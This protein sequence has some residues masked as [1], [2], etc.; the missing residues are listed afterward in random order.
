MLR[1]ALVILSGNAA[2]S[3]LLLARN[4]IVA[5]LIPVEDFGVAAT[6]AL[7]MALVEM[8]STF[9]LQQQIVQSKDGDDPRFQAALQGFQ[10]LRGVLSGLALF[11][12]AGP[13]ARFLEIPQVIWAYQLLALVPVLSAAQH[14][15]IHR[16]TRQMRFGPMI[17]TGA[18]PALAAVLV[19]WPLSLWFGDWQIML[20]SILVQAAL[21]TAVSHLLAE[22]PWRLVLD[23][24]VIAGS[25]RFG[26]PL[27][28]NA[29]LMFLIFQGD[30]LIVGR[31]LGM[32]ALA[33][34]SMGVTLTL[35]P[36]L[37]L[38]KSVQNL[39]LPKLS[40]AKAD[41]ARF[42]R[43]AAAAFQIHLIFGSALVFGAALF[44]PPILHLLLGPKYA[45]L[46][47]LLIWMAV[48]QALRLCKGGPSAVA[49]ARGQTE[50][51]LVA[52]L[53]RVAL[54]PLAWWVVVQGGDVLIVVQLG[55]LGEGVGLIVALV[56]QRVRQGV[57]LRPLLAPLACGV[58][59]G[60][61]A[62]LWA[63]A[64]PQALIW[65]SGAGLGL[66]LALSRDLR[67][68]RRR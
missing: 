9:G 54:L 21:G 34:F 48:Q 32:A 38:A 63:N 30:R 36:T 22:R 29:A 23:R 52:N 61:S 59:S 64:G 31:E 53:F 3:L 39:M 42:Q 58:L 57:A 16:Q 40:A 17:A 35:T 19:I 62:L 67:N 4:L 1:K 66:T 28:A 8:A 41:P 2:A 27:L 68:L 43:L 56:L 49:V 60:V 24:A 12:L 10:M 45:A 14:F 18:L 50:N 37:V 11:A 5:R 65:L 46:A 33:V 7:A 26:W 55:I 15:D 47:P 6:F 13:L 44:G 25:L 51:A 20:W